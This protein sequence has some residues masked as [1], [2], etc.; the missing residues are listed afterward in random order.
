MVF[1]LHTEVKNSAVLHYCLCHSWAQKRLKQHQNQLLSLCPVSNRY[2][3]PPGQHGSCK[4]SLHLGLWVTQHRLHCS[5][6]APTG[7]GKFNASKS[8]PILQVPNWAWLL[9]VAQGA[10]LPP[11]LPTHLLQP[12]LNYPQGKLSP[13]AKS[14]RADWHPRGSE[15]GFWKWRVALLS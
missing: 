14:C 1:V 15:R 5:L 7:K 13:P 2:C 8:Q 10:L 12:A 11:Q 6:L 9:H 4:L 3:S